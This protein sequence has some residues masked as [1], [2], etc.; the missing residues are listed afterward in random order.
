M[1]SKPALYA[2]AVFISL[3][4]TLIAGLA[5]FYLYQS[6]QQEQT[7][8]AQN[9][10]HSIA[11]TIGNTVKSIDYTLQ[12]AADQIE[13]LRRDKKASYENVTAFLEQQQNR[14]P[15]LDLLRAT[16]AAGITVYGR[17]VDPKQNASLAEREYYKQL[18]E[19]P[20]S[21][22]V[23]AEPIIG[24]ISQ[25]WIWLMAR[26]VNHEDGAFAGLVYGSIF[27]DDIVKHFSEFNLPTGSVISLRDRQLRVVARKTLGN[28]EQIKIGDNQVSNELNLALSIN[29]R[30]GTYVSDASSPDGVAR[31]LAYQ[32]DDKYGFTILVGIPK[33]QVTSA[34]LRQ[35]AVVAALL[36]ACLVGLWLSVRQIARSQEES[37]RAQNDKTRDEERA[38]LKSLIQNIPDL[39][40]LKDPE[41]YYLACNREFEK[42]FGHPENEI[43]G[44]TDFD[45]VPK[46]LAEAF[47]QNDQ[48]AIDAGRPTTNEEWITYASN[49]HR[50]LLVTTKAPIYKTD[51]TL[52]G[53]LGIGH[54]ITDIHRI[55][56]ELEHHRN[57]LQQLVDGRTAELND[58][59]QKLIDTEFAM[60][61]VG[62]GITW[63]DTETGRFLYSNE[64]HA[65]VLGYSREEMLALRISDI[66]PNFPQEVLG[67]TIEHI[68]E[69]GFVQ[70]E[71]TQLKKNGE[72]IPAEMTVY[73]HPGENRERPRLIAFMTDITRRKESE[74]ALLHAKE[75]AEAANLHL[76]KSDQRL[77][78]MF[79]MSQRASELPEMDLLRMG[80]DECVRL[81]DSQIGYIHFVNDDQETIALKT[82]STGTLKEC[83]AAY[84]DHYPVSA[85]GVWADSVRY[86]KPVIHNDY[87]NLENRKGCPQGHVKLSRHIGVPVIDG[88]KVKLLIGVG[89]KN[90]DYDESDVSQLQLIGNDLWSIVLRR[91][92]EIALAEAKE[93]AE[94]AT[95]AKSTF[96]ANMSH[97]I[98]TPMNAITGLV[99]LMRKDALTPLQMDRLSKIDLSSKHLLSIINDILDLS[100]IE[101]GKLVLEE[102]DFAL[103]QVLDHTASIIGNSAQ[104][105]GLTVAVDSDHVPVWL[106]GDA[107]RIRQ[108]LLNFAGNAVKFTDSG[109]ITLRAELID[110]K[111]DQ[112]KV[113]FSVEDTG[114]GIANENLDKLFHDFEQADSSTTRKYGGTGLGLAITRRLAEMMGGEAGCESTQGQGS[115]FW[116]SAWLQRGR[117]IMPPSENKVLSAEHE[118]RARHEGTRVLL[119]EDNLINVE[120]ALQLLHGVHLW[121]DVA[122]NGLIALEK[123]KVGNYQIILMDMQ[124]P[125]MDGL[126]ATRA[127]RALPELREIPILAM[128]ANAFDDD[129]KACIEVGMNDFISKPVEPE[130]LYSTILKWLPE[131]TR[132]KQKTPREHADLPNKTQNDEQALT[133]LAAT[134]GIDIQLGLRILCNHTDKYLQLLNELARRNIESIGSIKACLNSGDLSTAERLVHSLK[135]AS[136]SLGLIALFEA[137]SNLNALLRQEQFDQQRAKLL[138]SS[139]EEAQLE[140]SRALEGS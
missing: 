119:A 61:K 82:W 70:F 117:G 34:W 53:V 114:I 38:L 67:Q 6:T 69:K 11:S 72:V 49:G 100:K 92:I 35:S 22:M 50:A 103:C 54:E 27:I 39:V 33:S 83:Q 85:A 109:S 47:R 80:I 64:Y 108:A 121:V 46:E 43:V 95:L 78:A 4:A 30:M 52:A 37:L 94:A 44:K 8:V 88:G 26:R 29:P 120:V 75:G 115:K 71:T 79:A 98:R 102:S 87:P 25:K 41:G 40:W 128:T 68:R 136:G 15:E 1:K 89:N 107:L 104:A 140:L 24:K 116:F 91:R 105:K 77:S 112:V 7:R 36:A 135:G 14:L 86:L 131:E 130:A 63:A 9:L 138:L 129:R 110:D 55:Q 3:I 84:D 125:E 118:L 74:L 132:D 73:Y 59:L 97:E 31:V 45:F 113:R 123:A 51:S 99:H 48:L 2:V 19:N 58:A 10:A 106:R 124:M 17:G 65:K 28:D 21:G 133:R 139:V 20:F 42:F 57:N 23:I 126:Q 76:I 12:V 127:I 13:H 5:V 93:A 62:I 137:A 32:R 60:E 16:N 122:E 134:P 56:E 96:L 111:P 66:D 90:E 81:T 101:A 18:K